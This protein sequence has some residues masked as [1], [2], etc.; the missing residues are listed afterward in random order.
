MF[1]A[2][3]SWI[4]LLSLVFLYPATSQAVTIVTVL[5]DFD[6]PAH[7]ETDPYPIDLGV[8]GTFLYA[9]PSDVVINS[10]SFSGTYGTQT[11][12][13]STAGFDAV[14]GGETINVC[15]PLDAGCW[16]TGA[17]FRPFSFSLAP[18]TFGT[19]ATGIVAL[20]IVQTNQF[21]VRLGTPTLT[22]D[23]TAVPEP[24]TL[25]TLGSG[26]AALALRRRRARAR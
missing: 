6:G 7:L 4:V 8:V 15:V 11:F 26:L 1:R 24:A 13:T 9:L 10:A 19:L 3:A 21:N 5:P 20:D 18:S 23:Y 16:S 14:I 2:R 17:S 12:S 25:L 22:V